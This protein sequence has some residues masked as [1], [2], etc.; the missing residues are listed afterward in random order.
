MAFDPGKAKGVD[1]TLR[2]SARAPAGPWL[3]VAVAVGLAIFGV[4]SFCEACWRK[5]ETVRA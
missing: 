1:G 5:V 3:L 4:Y 2:E